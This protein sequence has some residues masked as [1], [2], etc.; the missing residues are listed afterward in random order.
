MAR[1]NDRR[2]ISGIEEEQR[3]KKPHNVLSKEVF[4]YF[5]NIYILVENSIGAVFP[6]SIYAT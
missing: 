3:T 6:H 5:Y 2:A 1:E 4:R